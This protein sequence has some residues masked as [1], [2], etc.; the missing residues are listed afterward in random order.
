MIGHI[1]VGQEGKAHVALQ[2]GATQFTVIEAK[3]G[4]RLS[5]GTSNAPYF[6]QAA[7]SVACMAETLRRAE[8]RPSDMGRPE[9]VVLAS[10]EAVEAGTFSGEMAPRSI[11]EKV[12]RK[13]ASY[14]G[15]LDGWHQ[16]WFES[17]LEALDLQ[18]LTWERV[19]EWLMQHVK[20]PASS[21]GKFYE[22]CL[23]FN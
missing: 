7:R 16:V 3:L 2:A 12:Q 22:S 15:G 11:Q 23:E 20:E 19:R 14:Q 18:V 9:F 21:L 1:S 4:S 8:R 5:K 6:D 13:I 10:E 17:S